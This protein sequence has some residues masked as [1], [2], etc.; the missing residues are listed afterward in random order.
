[1]LREWWYMCVYVCIFNSVYWYCTF[2]VR[3]VCE[4]YKMPNWFTIY[5]MIFEISSVHFWI[6][7][8]IRYEWI[9]FHSLVWSLLHAFFSM[10]YFRINSLHA[11]SSLSL[12]SSSS[13]L[14][15]SWSS[16]LLS[17]IMHLWV[18]LF[19]SHST[20]LTLGKY[21]LFAVTAASAIA[22]TVAVIV[23]A[24]GAE[25][26]SFIIYVNVFNVYG[27]GYVL[28]VST[29]FGPCVFVR[30][31]AIHCSVITHRHIHTYNTIIVL[32]LA[33]SA[34]ARELYDLC[35]CICARIHT[36]THTN[37][38]TFTFIHQCIYTFEICLL[39]TYRICIGWLVGWLWLYAWTIAIR[40]E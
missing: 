5:L 32:S 28:C 14:L 16:S 8:A 26:S 17:I 1:M 7:I 39:G 34:R 13:L 31:C 24:A 15:L 19:I 30:K 37:T 33:S 36:H 22:A 18:K 40:L 3:P 23:V 12:S 27:Y 10:L 29:C 9:W 25:W 11:I 35:V 6:K 4:T 21:S 20:Y 38:H 2:F